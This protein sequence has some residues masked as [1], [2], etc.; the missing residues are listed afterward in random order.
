MKRE[1]GDLLNAYSTDFVL[2][3]AG[4]WK[5]P[6]GWF[7]LTLDKLKPDNVLSLCWDGLRKTGSTTFEF[8][9][10]NFAPKH[11]VQML[12]LSEN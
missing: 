11:D 8:A 7:R 10:A 9:A 4:N 12:V 5:G 1:E 6:I 2:S 3:T